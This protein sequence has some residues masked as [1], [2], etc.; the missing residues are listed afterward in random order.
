MGM[1]EVG[2]A[3]EIF[4]AKIQ[5]VSLVDAAANKRKFLLK[6]AKD[7][8]CSFVNYGRIIKADTES[9]YVTGIVYEPMTEDTDG[10]FM[11]AEE[12]R[13]A[14]YFYVKNSE[15]VDI[16]H[17]FEP[18]TSCSVVE[19][20]IAKAD[21]SLGGQDV[22]EGT[23]LMTVEVTN[24][25]LWDRI[26]KGEITGFSMGGVCMSSEEE[27]DLSEVEK[28]NEK[29]P[30]NKG[31][32]TKFAE[33]LGIK[34]VEKG[35][36]AEMYEELAKDNDFWAAMD[37]LRAALRRYNSVN[38]KYVYET[39]EERIRE[40]LEDFSGIITGILTGSKPL[41]K[42]IEGPEEI[43]K[44]EDSGDEKDPEETTNTIQKEDKEVTRKEAEE[45]ITQ[46]VAKALE[47]S[48]EQPDQ[49]TTDQNAAPAAAPEEV[50]KAEEKAAEITPELLEQMV[51]EAVAKAQQPEEPKISMEDIQQMI[52]EEV[53]KAMEPIR[54]ANHLPS[55]LNHETVGKSEKPE[56][57]YL[58]GI[59]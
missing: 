7:G 19:S 33:F 20:W 56:D 52:S 42:A 12:I 17:S 29:Q 34:V 57:H 16:Q 40:A 31:L 47:K 9:H 35:N 26:Q 48:V 28:N 43:E 46:A 37:S 23:W 51:T 44:S 14:A 2:K 32:L 3:R 1:K 11:T 58:H 4:N 41:A 45:L 53:A 15:S 8:T 13:K 27:V 54:K 36:V 55:N 5:Y 39:D 22:K 30:E 38:D 24:D 25:D 6:K 10:E 21:F 59:L 49:Q 18:E 50:T